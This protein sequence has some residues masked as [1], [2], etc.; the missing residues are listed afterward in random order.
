MTKTSG[1]REPYEQ[2]TPRAVEDLEP[3]NLSGGAFTQWAHAVS[4]RKR[5][6]RSNARKRKTLWPQDDGDMRPGIRNPGETSH[7]DQHVTRGARTF[8]A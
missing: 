3:A 6:A 8:Q 1:E 2:E 5:S 4:L 7:V